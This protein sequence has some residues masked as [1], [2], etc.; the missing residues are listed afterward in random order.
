MRELQNLLAIVMIDNCDQCE[1]KPKYKF[2]W[3]FGASMCSKGNDHFHI[4]S[5]CKNLGKLLDTGR[6]DMTRYWN[7]RL[8]K[9][10][11][12]PTLLI[13]YHWVICMFHLR[14]PETHPKQSHRSSSAW[15]Y[16]NHE[17]RGLHSASSPISFVYSQLP[18]FLRLSSPPHLSGRMK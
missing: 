1:N 11:K 14:S 7:G 4:G 5:D 6:S 8:V 9:P 3:V 10:V 18:A 16:N 2:L 12:S 17:S 15:N 13:D